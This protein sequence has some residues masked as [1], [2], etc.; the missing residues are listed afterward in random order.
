MKTKSQ[1]R[2][3]KRNY[4]IVALIVVLLLLAVGY[5]SFTQTLNISGTASGSADWEVIFTEDSDGTRS[6]DN[7]TLTVTTNDLAYPGDAKEVTAVIQN[8]SSM[9]IKLTSFNVTEPTGTDISIDYVDLAPLS[10]ETIS[11]NGGTCTYKFIVKWNEDST[12]TSVS[13]TYSFT[14][15][16]EQDTTASTLTPSHTH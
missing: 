9:D 12:A 4:I 8:N 14:F 11:A 6:N 3:N 1:T 13:D 7:H 2:K 15:N 10:N 5:A 16:Y